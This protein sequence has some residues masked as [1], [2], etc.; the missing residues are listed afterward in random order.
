MIFGRI[1]SCSGSSALLVA[2]AAACRPLCGYLQSDDP[3]WLKL[4]HSPRGM[5]SVER[6]RWAIPSPLEAGY[7]RG[8]TEWTKHRA[9]ELTR[10]PRVSQ[11]GGA[12]AMLCRCHRYG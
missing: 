12:D 7:G 4:V 9:A 5:I 2:P 6:V 11:S 1:T 3:T 8:T 10:P